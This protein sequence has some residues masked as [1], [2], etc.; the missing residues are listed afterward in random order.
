MVRSFSYS[1]EETRKVYRSLT[2]FN[3]MIDI[4]SLSSVLGYISTNFGTCRWPQIDGK[5]C[6]NNLKS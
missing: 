3:L 1:S 5:L 6:T 4:S 2:G